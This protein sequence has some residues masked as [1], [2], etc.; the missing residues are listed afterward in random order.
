MNTLE[1]LKKS[2]KENNDR[3]KED[4]AKLIPKTV[5]YTQEDIQAAI[6]SAITILNRPSEEQNNGGN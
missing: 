5:T 4:I 6:N 1:F 3:L 2:L